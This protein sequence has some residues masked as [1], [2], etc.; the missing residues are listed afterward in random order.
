MTTPARPYNS[1]S[2]SQ[3]QEVCS[4]PRGPLRQVPGP[5][6]GVFGDDQVLGVLQGG[7]QGRRTRG[8]GPATEVLCWV[9]TDLGEAELP[10]RCVC[11]RQ[12]CFQQAEVEKQAL[13]RTAATPA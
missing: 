11:H 8:S 6:A 4:P 9:A 1:L 2:S 3:Q 13:S 7:G 5:G 10:C 12:C